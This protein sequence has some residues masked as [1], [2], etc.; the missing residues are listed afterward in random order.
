MPAI[1]T[2]A[3]TKVYRRT[4]LGKV[5]LS[6]GIDGMN[7]EVEEGEIFGLLG[8][9]GS[10][11]TTTIKLIVGLLFATSGRI[12]VFGSPM[13]D[14]KKLSLI[15]YLPE[16][17]Y[18][19]KFF[20]GRETLNFY[21]ELSGG[22][23]RGRIDEIAGTLGMNSYM[24]KR[25]GEYSKGM[26]Q[27]LTIAQTLLSD[28]PLFVFDEL[29]SGLDPLGIH[30]MRSFVLDLKKKG[31]TLFFSSH[32]ISEVEKVCDRVGIIHKG[33]LIR[34]LRNDDWRGVSLEDIFINTI[35]GEYK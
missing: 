13:P 33:R 20:T 12:S 30:D 29:V 2:E 22:I 21:G 15:G 10:G 5:F 19:Q 18:F 28:P 14:R 27:R 26:M 9:N 16:M 25:I 11:K 31:K 32:L 4:H 17:P 8:L 6:P 1:K 34:I 23:P 35:K 7:L 3:L 24:D